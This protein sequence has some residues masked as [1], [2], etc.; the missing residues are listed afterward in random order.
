MLFIS[1]FCKK[2]CCTT[3]CIL[4][5]VFLVSHEATIQTSHLWFLSWVKTFS[6]HKSRDVSK[7]VSL[8]HEFQKSRYS[9]RQHIVTML[10]CAGHSVLMIWRRKKVYFQ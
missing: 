6:D 9:A 2:N 4:L 7:V 8:G 3:S 5:P 1:L 10:L